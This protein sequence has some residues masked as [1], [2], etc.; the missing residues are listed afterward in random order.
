M[1]WCPEREL[2]AHCRRLFNR[3]DLGSTP[4]F[5]LPIQNSSYLGDFVL[6]LFGSFW[7]AAFVLSILSSTEGFSSLQADVLVTLVPLGLGTLIIFIAARSARQ[8]YL[9][10]CGRFRHGL[11]L[12]EDGLLVR[13]YVVPLLNHKSCLWLPRSL[14]KE[15]SMGQFST[16]RTTYTR[17]CITYALPEQAAVW[18]RLPRFVDDQGILERIESWADLP[19]QKESP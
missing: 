2:P 10:R 17:V 11:Y 8:K 5:R 18:V 19:Q 15:V 12:M 6:G 3:Q 1:G 4:F 13:N 7:L 9:L 14:I 16:S